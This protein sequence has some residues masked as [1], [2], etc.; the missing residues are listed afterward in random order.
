VEGKGEAGE[1][2]EE[3]SGGDGAGGDAGAEEGVGLERGE[4]RV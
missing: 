3:G 1:G 4:R 2:V